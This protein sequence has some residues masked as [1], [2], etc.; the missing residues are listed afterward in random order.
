M[1]AALLLLAAAN[2]E[3]LILAQSSECSDHAGDHGARF[4]D[5]AVKQWIVDLD[6]DSSY[7]GGRWVKAIG[8]GVD[9]SSAIRVI[10]PSTGERDERCTIA[11][12]TTAL[13][14][15]RITISTG[16]LLFPT[17]SFRE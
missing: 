2:V 15:L 9:G 6:T 13:R 5:P 1:R 7:I 4:L 14:I 12:K 17:N 16:L 10:D 11:L 8:L 3:A